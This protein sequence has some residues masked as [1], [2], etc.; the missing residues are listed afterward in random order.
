MC[1]LFFHFCSSS[2]TVMVFLRKK[3]YRAIDFY[4]VSFCNFSLLI[5]L[6]KKCRWNLFVFFFMLLLKLGWE[7]DDTRQW[8]RRK[9]LRNSATGWFC[10]LS[11]VHFLHRLIFELRRN[12]EMQLK[13]SLEVET[14]PKFADKK[15]AKQNKLENVRECVPGIYVDNRKLT[16][17]FLCSD[18]WEL[19][20]V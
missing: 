2:M 19:V 18:R 16:S 3:S 5:Y 20:L 14:L 17:F 7:S 15:V 13:R 10:C 11:C 4:Q 8:I 6:S 1:L 12:V 9:G